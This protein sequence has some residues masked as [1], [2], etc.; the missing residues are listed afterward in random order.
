MMDLNWVDDL[1]TKYIRPQTPPVAVKLCV[2]A[3]QL[4]ERVKRPQRDFKSK[5]PLCMAIA[6][7]RR[8]G[9]VVAMGKEDQACPF[10]ALTMGFV[11]PTKA[12][13]NGTVYALSTPEAATKTAQALSRLEAGKYSHML[14]A[15]LT[16]TSFEPDLIIVYGNPAQVGRLT[17]ATLLKR[18]GALTTPTVGGI[19]CSSVIA[20]TMIQDEC[21]YVAVGAGDRIFAL[22]QD[23]EMVFTMPMS[24][25]ELTLNSLAE[26]HKKGEARYPTL[27]YLRFEPKLPATFHRLMENLEKGD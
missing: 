22:T 19:A 20:R 26:S 14:V 24:K 2:S 6:M 3:D 18:G 9:W 1:L 15:P 11:A 8:Y 16:R 23:H 21:Q 13:L 10:G 25:V 12:Y 27:S 4:P 7:A 17:Q 5:I